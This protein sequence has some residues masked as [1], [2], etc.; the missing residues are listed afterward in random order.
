MQSKRK[1]HAVTAAFIA[2]AIVGCGGSGKSGSTASNAQVTAALR[3]SAREMDPRARDGEH[4]MEEAV[5]RLMS[6]LNELRQVPVLQ[7]LFQQYEVQQPVSDDDDDEAHG[8]ISFLRDVAIHVDDGTLTLVNRR[9]GGVIY[10][11]PLSDLASGTFH[12]ENVPGTTTPPPP[13]CTYAYSAWSACA[14]GVQTRTV[15]DATPAGC[16]GTPVLSQPCSGTPPTTCTSFTYSVWGACQPDG[17]QARTVLSSSPAGCTGG[18]PVTTQ[19]CTYV[20]PLDGAALYGANCAG[21]HG[22]LATSNLKGRNISVSLIKSF[23]MTRGLSDAQL[24]A[25]VDAIGP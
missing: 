6:L 10:E 2:A 7:P 13:V 3:A 20:P 19:A 1:F 15:I 4:E 24:Q 21:C 11:A 12:P 16:T 17:T 18:A 5:T 23:N 22:P 25:I 14:G 8:L 9:T